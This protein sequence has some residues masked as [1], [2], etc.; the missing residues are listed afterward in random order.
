MELLKLNTTFTATLPIFNGTYPNGT[1]SHCVKV[2][3]KVLK[4]NTYKDSNVIFEVIESTD[5]QNFTIGKKYKKQYQN[6]YNNLIL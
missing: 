3:A 1:L 2:T 5:E 4:E 6:L